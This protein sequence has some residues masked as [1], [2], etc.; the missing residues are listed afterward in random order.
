MKPNMNNTVT[1][2]AVKIVNNL[3]MT[4]E[5][6]W[7]VAGSPYLSKFYPHQTSVIFTAGNGG[8]A[9]IANHMACDWMKST[10][11]PGR[12]PIRVISL[13]SNMELL[14]ALGND[15]GYDETI[16]RQI[17]W[18]ARKSH[19]IILI[20]SSGTSKNIVK[21]AEEAKRVGCKLIGFTGNA[22]NSDGGPLRK[23]ADVS[24]HCDS[25]DYGI[26]EDFHSQVMHEV[27]RIIKGMS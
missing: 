23:W 5:P 12:A 6:K 24:V 7:E 2:A 20:S 17:E 18:L 10:H 27:V 3:W 11:K 1:Q 19:V 9:S 25:N 8:S 4:F 16:S 26:I 13:V 14:T 21:A 15:L 22:G